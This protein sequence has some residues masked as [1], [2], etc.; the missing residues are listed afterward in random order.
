MG[1]M[2]INFSYNKSG[3]IW[4]ESACCARHRKAAR[5]TDLFSVFRSQV[6][7]PA[8]GAGRAARGADA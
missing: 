8:R 4:C 7:P 5:G 2:N 1:W 6:L 3:K